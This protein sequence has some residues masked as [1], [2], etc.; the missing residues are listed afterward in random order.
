MAEFKNVMEIFQHLEKSNCKKCNE[1]TCLAFAAAVFT[2]KKKLEECP[3]IDQNVLIKY[4]DNGPSRPGIEQDQEK[5]VAALKKK[6][7][8][9]DLL[10]VADRIG[11]RVA[12]NKLAIRCLGKE[13]FVDAR[14][15]ITSDAHIHPGVTI[16]ILNY[17]LHC[18]TEPT[19]SQWTPLRELKNG[20]AYAPLFEKRSETPFKKIADSHTSLFKDLMHLFNGKPGGEYEGADLSLVLYPLPKV[21]MLICYW[22]PEDG[23]DSMLHIFF[24]KTAEKNLNIESVYILGAGFT[25]MIEKLAARHGL[26]G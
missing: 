26:S 3:R 25:Q 4:G 5:M 16:P 19:N 7:A 2:G 20:A 17:V 12:G 22:Q 24:D 8:N 1:P 21:P 18:K 23:L 9:I 11:A 10:A 14:G 15:N 13:F 6:V